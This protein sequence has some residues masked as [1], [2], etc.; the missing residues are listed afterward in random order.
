VR[1]YGPPEGL[2]AAGGWAD[3]DEAEWGEGEG[4]EGG[5]GQAEDEELLL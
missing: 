4:D 2:R 5:E 1:V 3:D